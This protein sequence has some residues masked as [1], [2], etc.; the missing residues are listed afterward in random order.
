MTQASNL[1][2]FANNLNS[3]GQMDPNALSTVLPIAKG[4]TSASTAT[5][6][7]ANLD[8][9]KRD[10]TNATGSWAINIT[11]NAATST[12]ATNAVNATNATNASYA[13]NA[14]YA[15]TAGNGGVTSVNG[16]TGAV[17]VTSATTANVLTATAAATAGVVGT[18]GVVIT[19]SNYSPGTTVAGNTLFPSGTGT[20]RCMRTGNGFQTYQAGSCGASFVTV[21]PSTFLRIS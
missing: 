20:W 21:Y 17:S 2:N 9:P 18:Y 6:A 16:A 1:A 10:G 13:T 5:D 7:R 19:G 11:G 12:N 15:T 8:V 4:G 3:S 14:G